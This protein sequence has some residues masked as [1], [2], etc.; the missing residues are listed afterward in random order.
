MI[1][2]LS[3]KYFVAPSKPSAYFF[4][5]HVSNVDEQLGEMFIEEKAPTVDELKVIYIRVGV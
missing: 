5:E 3:I 1:T 4:T 2:F